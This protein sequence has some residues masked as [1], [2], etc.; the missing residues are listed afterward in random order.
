MAKRTRD[1]LTPIG[2]RLKTKTSLLSSPYRVCFCYNDSVLLRQ[3]T[4]YL[5]SPPKKEKEGKTLIRIQATINQLVIYSMM[6]LTN[7]NEIL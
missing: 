2:N 7:G 4:N 5:W 6:S 1:S 3:I